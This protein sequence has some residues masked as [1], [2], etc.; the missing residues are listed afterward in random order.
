MTRA[1]RR[2][3]R[4]SGGPRGAREAGRRT[5]RYGAGGLALLLLLAGLS[6]TTRSGSA[7]HPEPRAGLDHASHVVPAARYDA[8]PRVAQT[9]EMVA[10]V[11]MIVDGVYCYCN[12]AEHSGHY[13][14]LDC[15]AS[16]H[17]AR[18]DVC[19]SEATIAYRMSTDGADLRAIRAEIDRR[20][21]S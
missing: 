17:A 14:L 5:L 16:D 21:G 15:F 3:E 4:N 12:C 10:A 13:S 19:L 1:Q 11:P 7:P 20:F 6:L 8:Y 2:H 18:C 9:Y